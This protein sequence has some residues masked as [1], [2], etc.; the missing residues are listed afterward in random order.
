MVFDIDFTETALRDLAL[1]KRHKP[2]SYKKA[3]KLIGEL[4]TP[5][6]PSPTRTVERRPLRLLV[7]AHHTE[8]PHRV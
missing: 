6:C 2:A 4:R 3:L 1:Q 8:T 7:K 5:L